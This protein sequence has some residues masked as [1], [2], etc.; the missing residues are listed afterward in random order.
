M[1]FDICIIGGGASGL[2]AAAVA[3]QQNKNLNIVILERLDR[4]GKKLAL[5]GNGRCNITNRSISDKN[6]Y[7]KDIRFAKTV[8][9]RFSVSDTERFFEDIGVP[10]IYEGSKG[11]PSSLQ[12]ASVTD[13]LRFF[14]DR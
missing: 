8:L 13:A 4:V 6:Y 10:V 5:T 12:A 14:C 11:Y 1:I 7:G 3:K 9:D 2:L